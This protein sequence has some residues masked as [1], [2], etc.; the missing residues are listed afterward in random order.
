VTHSFTVSDKQHTLP[1]E[2]DSRKLTTPEEEATLAELV[3]VQISS[4]SEQQR[5]Q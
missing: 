2:C 4:D 1:C 5:L 3:V